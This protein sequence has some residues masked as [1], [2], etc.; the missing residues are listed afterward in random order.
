MKY[1]FLKY[2]SFLSKK[3]EKKKIW[4]NPLLKRDS[5]FPFLLIKFKDTQIPKSHISFEK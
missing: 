2:F 1:Y 5:F 3:T 4:M